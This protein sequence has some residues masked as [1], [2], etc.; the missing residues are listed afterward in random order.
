MCVINKTADLCSGK[1]HSGNFHCIKYHIIKAYF[2]WKV[3][4]SQ[5]FNLKSFDVAYFKFML[6]K[7]LMIIF[8][9]VIIF[10]YKKYWWY[11][12][13][14]NHLIV[15]SRTYCHFLVYWGNFINVI[16]FFFPLF[17]NII[18]LLQL[19]NFVQKFIYMQQNNV[20]PFKYVPY[21]FD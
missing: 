16:E 6:V 18:I 19:W 3:Q 10:G 20:L 1:F 12:I 8:I 11:I 17:I 13:H 7:D 2:K 9:I 4:H 14:T 15:Y 21:Y 5:D